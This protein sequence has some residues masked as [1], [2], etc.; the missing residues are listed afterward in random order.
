MFVA[1]LSAEYILG[2]I[3]VWV[4]APATGRNAFRPL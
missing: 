4:K 1:F 2:L 3:V